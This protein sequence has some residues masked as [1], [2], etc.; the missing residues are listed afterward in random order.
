M[1]AGI[2]STSEEGAA[3]SVSIEAL[4]IDRLSVRERLELIEQIWNSLPEQV[5]PADFP[6]WHLEELARRRAAA[7]ARPGVG[8]PWREVLS[9]LVA[10]P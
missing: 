5:D 8:K 9:S 3:M 1:L 10:K 7:A 6:P 4:G 2:R